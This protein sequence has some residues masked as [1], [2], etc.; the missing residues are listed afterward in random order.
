MALTTVMPAEIS[1]QN[2]PNTPKVGMT[3]NTPYRQNITPTTSESTIEGFEG[4]ILTTLLLR[5]YISSQ[6]FLYYDRAV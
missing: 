2:R 3:I 5:I 1:V 6:G 4:W